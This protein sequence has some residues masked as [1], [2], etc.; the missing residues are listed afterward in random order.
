MEASHKKDRPNIQVGKDAE[1][2]VELRNLTTTIEDNGGEL[3]SAW[4]D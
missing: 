4:K 2:E 1:E 3:S